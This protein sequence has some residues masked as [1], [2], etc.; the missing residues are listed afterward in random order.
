MS[1]HKPRIPRRTLSAFKDLHVTTYLRGISTAMSAQQLHNR[2]SR[3]LQQI[4]L[5]TNL[6]ANGL[7][8]DVARLARC[9]QTRC[10]IEAFDVESALRACGIKSNSI[11]GR[12]RH[13][14]AC[15]PAKY[16]TQLRLAAS[17]RLLHSHEIAITEIAFAV[18]YSRHE[19]FS[20]AFNRHYGC[21]PSDY[22]AKIRVMEVRSR[23]SAEE[24]RPFEVQ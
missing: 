22:R 16:L 2:V 5:Q 4:R 17:R 23:N 9:I 12:F 24:H 21:S 15:T 1:R 7:P 3:E 10:F 13:H 18:G 14:V 6:H 19:T 20:R 8:H 11:Y